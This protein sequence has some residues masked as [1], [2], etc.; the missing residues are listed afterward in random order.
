MAEAYENLAGRVEE[1]VYRNPDN[2]YTV[3]QLNTGEANGDGETV[4]GEM[5]P[6][7][8]GEEAVFRGQWTMHPR[9]GRQFKA[10]QVTVTLPKDASGILQYL[11]GGI[12]KGIGPSTATKIVEAFGADSLQVIEKEPERLAELKGIS[13]SMAKKISREYK[14]QFASRQALEALAGMGFTQGEAFKAFSFFGPEAPEILAENPYAFVITG[15]DQGIPFERA[16]EIAEELPQAPDPSYRDQ[17][18][19]IYV[20]QYNLKNGHTCLPRRKVIQTAVTGLDMTEERAEMALDNALEAR[21]LV[22][23]QMD[24]QPFLF[25]PHIYEAEQGIGQRIRVMTQYP[26]RECEIFTSE[27]LA[28]EGAN[29]I[30]LDEKQRRAIEIATQKGLLTALS[31]PLCIISGGPGTGKTTTVKGI[32][33]MM[34]NRGLRVALAAPTGRAAQ[35]MTELTG[36]EAKTIHRLLETERRD[37]EPEPTF[38][39]NLRN[40]LDLDA[41]I[42]DELSMVDVLLFSALLDALPL[43]CRLILVGDVDQ[44]PP[45]GAGNVLSDLIAGGRIDVISLDKVFRQAQKSRIV[46]NAHRVV[47]GKMPELDCNTPDSDFFFLNTA[48]VYAV[49]RK[50]VELVTRRIPAGYGMDSIKD[51]QVLCPSR[52]GAAGTAYLNAQ[53]QAAL[54]PPDKHKA[55]LVTMGRTLREGDR[56]M[57]IKNNYDVPWFKKNGDSGAGVFNGDIGILTRIDRGQDILNVQFDDREAMYSLQNADQL[58]LAYAMTVHKSQGSEFSAVVM[59]TIGASPKLCYRNLFYTALTRAKSLLILVG[60]RESIQAMVENDKKMLRYSGLVHFLSVDNDGGIQ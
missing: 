13:R 29:G 53:L 7:S 17:A 14:N 54:N 33:A 43:H 1:I 49:P 28:Y 31:Y 3:L 44:L 56:V 23:E 19:V 26:P 39:H 48:S 6:I 38:V 47:A 5:P 8:E 34:K 41:V 20:V 42:V 50:V 30:E 57:Q 45:V 16:Q 15:N 12:I 55:E 36:S 60:T 58:D 18:A 27:I 25:L 35:R 2:G 51:I 21:Q 32:I 11:S 22:Q 37:G 59:P 10:V 52:K 40:P 4:A 46:T 9:F 24:E